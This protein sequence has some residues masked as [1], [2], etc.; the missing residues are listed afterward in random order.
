MASVTF[1]NSSVIE[2]IKKDPGGDASPDNLI[3]RRR[4]DLGNQ[5]TAM[6]IP[7]TNVHRQ[8]IK[9]ADL[10]PTAHQ[11]PG[12]VLETKGD[13]VKLE[14]TTWPMEEQLAAI[15]TFIRMHTDA[16]PAWVE[17]DNELLAQFVAQQYGCPVG[18]PKNWK[19]G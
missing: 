14:T 13:R 5:I 9:T 4:T 3:T 18:R 7:D 17:S 15:R 1:G 2:M 12:H 16:A 10:H 19:V 6:S 11:L 8:W